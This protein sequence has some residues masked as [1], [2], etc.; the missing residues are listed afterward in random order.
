MYW[1]AQKSK[2]QEKYLNILNFAALAVSMHTHDL[3][4]KNMCYN[5]NI[6]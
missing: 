3:L 5:N 1:L 4:S 6:L 2:D